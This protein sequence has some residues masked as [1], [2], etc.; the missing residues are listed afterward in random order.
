MPLIRRAL[1]VAGL[2]ALLA[3]GCGG[4]GSP[5][6]AGTTSLAPASA[7]TPT[8]TATT[9]TDAPGALP[10]E[11]AS[12]A[13]P[14]APPRVPGYTFRRETGSATAS[15]T[16]MVDRSAGVLTAVSVWNVARHHADVGG[17]VQFRIAARYASDPA[18]VQSLLPNIIGGLAGAGATVT[19]RTI[20]GVKVAEGTTH[21]AQVFVW[22]RDGLVDMYLTDPGQKSAGRAFVAAYVRAS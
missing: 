21:D 12:D 19:Q 15:I 3:T 10:S 20:A 17:L 4:G 5:Q 9:A 16:Q 18:L 11:T 2:V 1:P 8:A 13:A 6:G 14:P 7:V 22:F